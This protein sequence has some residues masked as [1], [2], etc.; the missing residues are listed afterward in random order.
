MGKSSSPSYG[1][2]GGEHGGAV[3]VRQAGKEATEDILAL[4]P[5]EESPYLTPVVPWE[6]IF[7]LALTATRKHTEKAI[8][9]VNMQ[10]SALVHC[11]ILPQQARVFLASLLQVMCSYQQEM[12]GMAT[13]QVVLP[14]QIVP[15]LLGGQPGYDGGSNPVG[16]PKLPCKLAGFPG[17]V[18][19]CRSHQ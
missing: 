3:L 12:D 6:D 10:L 17:Q 7:T 1:L 4:L 14:C 19:I 5:A 18:S 15:N 16:S 11:H 2:H 9:A 13:S 8:E